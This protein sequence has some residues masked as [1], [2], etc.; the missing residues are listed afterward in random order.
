MRPF[1]STGHHS[2][3]LIFGAAALA[4]MSTERAEATLELVTAAGLNHIDTAAAYG[5][6]ELRLA[7]WLADHRSEV[8]LATKTGERDGE[9]A[10]AELERSLERLGVDQVDLVQLHNLVEEEGWCRAF[11]P[12]GAVAALFE[13]RAEG[14][15]RHVGVTGHGLRIAAMHVRSLAEA[16][17]ASVLL[18]WSHGLA[19]IESYVADVTLLLDLCA[20]RGVAVQT[21]KSVA[22]RRWPGDG[23]P[24]RFSW[25]EPITEPDALRRSV[26]FVLADPRLFLN[27]SSD[28][29][30]LPAMIAAAEG[31]D[32][33]APEPG[34]LARDREAQGIVA[35]FDGAALDVI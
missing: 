2:S 28:A 13:A 16:P 11:S 22:R 35:L 27:T 21:I 12:G 34:L 20:E 24:R 6:S 32:G 23:S 33:S 18:P 25:Y 31:H 14:L 15:C 17:F 26:E 19:T 7:P 30:L 9:E 3:R 8:F 5:H 29:R 4:A 1:G 10:R